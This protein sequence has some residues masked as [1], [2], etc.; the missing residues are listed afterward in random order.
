MP[1]IPQDDRMRYDADINSII[2]NLCSR[3]EDEVKGH[4]NYIIFSI[5]KGYLD[6]KGMKYS[7]AQDLI[8][9][10]LTCCQMELYLRLLSPYEKQARERNGDI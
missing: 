8:G 6:E 1:Y 3:E 5:I 7:R 10:V 2:E 4:L 9:G